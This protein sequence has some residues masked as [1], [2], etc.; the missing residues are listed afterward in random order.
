MT[1]AFESPVAAKF[2]YVGEDVFTYAVESFAEVI[3]D[4]RPLLSRHWTEL[5]AYSDIPLDP[6][7]EF[8][9]KA[10]AADVLRIYTARKN[11][12]LIGY[13]LMTVLRSHPHYSG[14]P[15]SVSDI[16]LVVPEHRNFGVGNALFAFLERD[17][18]G[19]VV[20]IHSK[21]AHPEL[22]MLLKTRGYD[23]IEIT[24]SKRL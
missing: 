7:F 2:T 6:D 8:Y 19:F 10:N 11:G 20:Q 14:Q 17:L 9:R 13:V 16:V 12:A 1:D 22:G 5:A 18:E 4:I 24:Y 21:A 23:P 15:W 3:D